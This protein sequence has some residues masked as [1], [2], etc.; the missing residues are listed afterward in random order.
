MSKLLFQGFLD[1]IVMDRMM[2]DSQYQ[3]ANNHVHREYEIYYMLDG[4]GYYFIESNTY[5]VTAGTLVVIDSLQIHKTTYFEQ[6]THDRIL[7]EISKERL[8]PFFEVVFGHSIEA[9]FTQ[10][11]GVFSFDESERRKI[12]TLLFDMMKELETPSPHH[13]TMVWLQLAELCVLIDRHQSAH[14]FDA[15]GF[16]ADT[17]KHRNVHEIATYMKQNYNADLSLDQMAQRFFISKSYL[18]RIFKEVTGHTVHEYLHIQRIRHAEALLA[19][20]C[21]S[22]TE[23]ASLLGYQSSAYFGK[24]FKKYTE[25][26]PLK[27]R[28]KIDR[29]KKNI[30]QRKQEINLIL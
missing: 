20:P 18:S 29:L 9:F 1:G 14:R 27:Y 4:M 21:K 3:M 28:Q 11:Y 25:T 24:I 22:I 8:Q 30:R 26:S 13:Q 15:T 2:W 23:I 19:D 17:A 12:E 10:Q 6:Q 7:I 16:V 5:L